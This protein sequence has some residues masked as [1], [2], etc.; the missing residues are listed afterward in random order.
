MGAAI[1]AVRKGFAAMA[2]AALMVDVLSD[3][4]CDMLTAVVEAVRHV[5]T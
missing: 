1:G 3:G 2:V 5:A 4:D